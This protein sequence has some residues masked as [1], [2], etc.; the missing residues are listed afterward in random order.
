MD[1]Q[2]TV[3]ALR[4]WDPNARCKLFSG[5]AGETAAER[6]DMIAYSGG[7]IENHF[8]WGNLVI[9]VQGGIFPRE[10]YPILEDHFEENKIAFTGPP[11]ADNNVLRI[12]PETT[13]FLDTEESLKFRKIS[14]SGFPYQA[15]IYGIPVEVEEVPEGAETEV[16]GFTFAGPGNVWRKWEFMEASVCVFGW[17]RNTSSQAFRKSDGHVDITYKTV[18]TGGNPMTKFSKDDLKEL[19]NMFQDLVPELAAQ[20][21]EQIIPAVVEQVKAEIVPEVVAEV[22]DEVAGGEA[23]AMAD[24]DAPPD[25]T[26]SEEKTMTLEEAK[27]LL[28]QIKKQF[29]ELLADAAPSSGE[30]AALRRD[31][32]DLEKRLAHTE[33]DAARA[34]ADLIWSDR[35]ANTDIPVDKY[36]KIKRGVPFTKFMKNGVL[37]Q[38]KFAKAVEIELKEWD[39]MFSGGG[40]YVSRESDEE[41]RDEDLIERMAQFAKKAGAS[42][43]GRR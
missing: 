40:T 5:S 42:V 33:M 28:E 17:D 21:Q 8:F 11:L 18:K 4:L 3:N 38:A 37:E 22:K 31:Q 7:I 15:S 34:K 26:T 16:N 24:G 14:K 12:N 35:F 6:L 27:S 19:K 41:R 25:E 1:K 23:A 36:E 43:R 29:P 39:G 2:L 20:V 32:Y 13:V 30:A 10:K 9:D